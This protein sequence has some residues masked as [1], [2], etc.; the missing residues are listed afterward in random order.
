M[1]KSPVVSA[2]LLAILAT[3]LWSGNFIVARAAI[4]DIS[5]IHLA[6]G[7]WLVASLIMIP[8]GLKAL[9]NEWAGIIK[10]RMNILLAGLFG[11][12]I[13]NTIV[14][15]AGHH[16]EAIQLAL[17]GTTSS[18]VF[19][20]ILA[21][22]FLKEI[23]P[24]RRLIGLLICIVGILFILSKG[25][26]DTLLH[27]RFSPGD[28]WILLAAFSFAA[29]NIIVRGR[30]VKV[31]SVAYLSAVFFSG[32]LMLLPFAIADLSM[33]SIPRISLSLAGMILYLGAGTSVAAFF[34]WNVAIARLGAARASLFGML[35]PVFSSIE[36][37]WLLKEKM[38]FA[39][40]A[41]MILVFAGVFLANIN[42]VKKPL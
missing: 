13:F 10:G 36:A 4:N 15:V 11:V 31:S 26:L 8:I 3:F 22:I 34:C 32:T 39:Q 18:P 21:R 25:S 30:P 7:R 40:I 14:Y 12:C 33:G 1:P 42:P 24:A 2:F 5:P 6:F 20:F 16:S 29:Y 41:G 37:I 23:I 19:S 35:I 9:Q 17:L 38:I 27:L 28:W